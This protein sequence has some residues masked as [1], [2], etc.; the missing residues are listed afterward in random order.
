[1]AKI[2]TY[3]DFQYEDLL[4]Y[5]GID[6]IVTYELFKKLYG[7]LSTKPEYLTR[8]KGGIV[9]TV[10]APAIVEEALE[11]KKDA[12]EFMV[13]MMFNG[14]EYDVELNRQ[15]DL[16]MQGELSALKDKIH[17]ASGHVW[18]FDSD[19]EMEAVLFKALGLE[20]TIKTK[21]GKASTSGD[22]LKEMA[23]NYP[24]HT[25]LKD[26]AKY[27]DVASVHRSFISGYIEKHVKR[28]GRVH[29]NYNLHGTS[30]HRI[31]GDNP[32]L[33]NIPSP[34]HG[35]NIRKLFKVSDGMAFLT[36][37]FSS[38]EVKI[39]AALCKDKKMLEAILKGLDFHSYTAS[40][41]YNIDYETLVE[42]VDDE[43][44][45]NHKEYK[46]YRKNAKSVTFG[47]LYG[48]STAGVAMNI[49]C[50]TDE[51]QKIIDA[52]FVV[53]PDIKLFIEKCH[54]DAALNKW[55]YT[56]FKQRKMEYGLYDVFK[57]TAVYNAG[58][59]NAQ[60]VLIQSPAST[61]GLVAFSK[62]N[63]EIKKIGGK[64]ICTVYDSI[65]LEI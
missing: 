54:N 47:I 51:A 56:T 43:D 14:I 46:G 27:A 57:R 23:K 31:S 8:K 42:A 26:L 30:S 12:I 6:T 37:D 62:F 33:L 48:S 58:L 24:Q 35:Y 41:M 10:R 40:L 63:K 50:S 17:K 18:N 32:N 28:D 9:D 11:I 15:Y 2:R 4:T 55:V 52:Y 53:Y 61:L 22:A 38:C 39:L 36:F 21:K 3:E 60:N 49:G 19:L 1:M 20:T 29:P 64:A 16:R 13:D 44:H 25:W 65:E 45:P 34:K 7:R 5:A 59:R